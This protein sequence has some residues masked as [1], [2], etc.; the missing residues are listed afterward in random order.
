MIAN[1]HV[2]KTSPLGLAYRVRNV[3]KEDRRRTVEPVGLPEFRSVL[4]ATGFVVEEVH[5]HS[6]LP[7][8]GRRLPWL[9][10]YLTRPVE[11]T[12]R[13]LRL[14]HALAQSFIVVCRKVG[15]RA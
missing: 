13:A 11:A 3:L 6:Y 15:T 5:F 10:R 4:D 8:T 12:S 7:R 9:P 14:P 2:S 1:I